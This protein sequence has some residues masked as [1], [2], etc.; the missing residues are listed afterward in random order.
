MK[1]FDKVDK[2]SR[3]VVGG[4]AENVAGRISSVSFKNNFL[5]IEQK[6]R[7]LLLVAAK[8]LTRFDINKQ[9]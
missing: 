1:C 7:Q 8:A 4:K 6:H 2:W 3:W 9:R 5:L